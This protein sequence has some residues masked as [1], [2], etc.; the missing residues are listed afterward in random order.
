L[1]GLYLKR[2]LKVLASPGRGS[3]SRVSKV[4]DVKSLE[5]RKQ[6]TWLI[7]SLRNSWSVKRTFVLNFPW[8]A[9]RGKVDNHPAG[10]LPAY[11]LNNHPQGHCGHKGRLMGEAKSI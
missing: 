3:S 4:P 2:M 1:V 9:E 8:E 6:M 10:V 5:H 7:Q 11:T